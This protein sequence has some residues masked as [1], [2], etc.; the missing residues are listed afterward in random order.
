MSPDA[1]L[2]IDKP[3]EIKLAYTCLPYGMN[4]SHLILWN[5]MVY[6]L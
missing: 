2:N 1:L 6:D 4:T 3:I 5:L